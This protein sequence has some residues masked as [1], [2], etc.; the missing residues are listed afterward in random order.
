MILIFK[1]KMIEKLFS[2]YNISFFLNNVK[3]DVKFKYLYY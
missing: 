1:L 3:H 2:K